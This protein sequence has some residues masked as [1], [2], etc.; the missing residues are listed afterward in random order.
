MPPS[1]VR[2]NEMRADL[3]IF[4][5]RHL[6]W[7][8]SDAFRE[9]S[10]EVGDD[11]IGT[12]GM[13]GFLSIATKIHQRYGGE[14]VVAWEGHGNFRRDLYPDYKKKAEPDEDTL[15]LIHD[16]AKQ[17]KRLKAMLRLMGVRQY[18]GDGC[19]ADDVIGRLAK[20]ASER[21]QIVIIYSG[22][23]D[24]RQLVND[25]VYTA[26][27]GFR[28]SQDTLYDKEAVLDK[29]GVPPGYIADLKALSGDNSDNIPG[30]RGI[31]PV[32]AA[33]LVQSFGPV[34]KIIKAAESGEKIKWPVAERFKEPI[35]NGADDIR[36]FKKL[37]TIRTDMPWKEIT[38]K[39]D[40]ALLTKHLMAYRF[41]S[42]LASSEMCELMGMAG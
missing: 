19:E 6:L 30:I 8:T 10:A 7:R 41:R 36:L 22:D 1:L 32:T 21:D 35:I 23:S 16:M 13:Y 33:K 5:G 15:A 31:G 38:P 26:S 11:V 12:G 2:G 3:L 34:G 42:L 9:L 4:D 25:K 27:P 14:S 28:G 18:Y 20:E 37:T 39:R 17:E 29:H 24:L 40:K